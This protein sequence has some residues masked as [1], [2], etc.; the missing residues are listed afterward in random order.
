MYVDADLIN[1]TVALVAQDLVSTLGWPV[2]RAEA[3]VREEALSKARID[4]WNEDGDV[5]YALAVAE[6]TQQLLHD[7]FEDVTWPGCPAHG[8]HPLWLEEETSG[9]PT[10]RC[11]AD[12]AGYGQLGELATHRA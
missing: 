4:C 3:I 2:E 9:L 8:R 12:H 11:Q 6:D 5:A 1:R 7:T 10:W